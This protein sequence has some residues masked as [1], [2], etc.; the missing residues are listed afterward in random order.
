MK[1]LKKYEE[2]AGLTDYA[3][4]ETVLKGKRGRFPDEEIEETK[5]PVGTIVKFPDLA[6]G[7]E[8]KI[9]AYYP[10]KDTY[11]LEYP[12]GNE[13]P[14]ISGSKIESDAEIIELGEPGTPNE[15][16]WYKD[17]IQSIDIDDLD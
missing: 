13:S 1:H 4:Q 10:E 7:A 6:R 9:K 12:N 14:G 11:I 2:H 3:G 8:I 15:D 17:V 5:Y 16:T